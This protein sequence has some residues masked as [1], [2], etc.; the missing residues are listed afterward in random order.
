[1]EYEEK[2]EK[3]IQLYKQLHKILEEDGSQ[4]ADTLLSGVRHSLAIAEGVEG[5]E[6]FNELFSVYRLLTQP[7]YGLSDFFIWKDDYEERLVANEGL[8][9]IKKELQTI[10]WE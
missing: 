10:F 6:G 3:I 9:R 7:H 5:K 8:E 2:I 1:M 4:E